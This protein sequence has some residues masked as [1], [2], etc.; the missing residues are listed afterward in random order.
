MA[1]RIAYQ[2]EIQP[3]SKTTKAVKRPAYLTWIR[4]LPCVVTKRSDV[5][6]AHLSFFRPDLGHFG[7][8]MSQKASDRWCLPLCVEQHLLQ[9][10]GNEQAYWRRHGIDPHLACLVLWG[11]FSELGADAT[12]EAGKIITK[13][14]GR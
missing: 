11:L 4:T 3:F 12:D 6:A 14:I 5:Q 8:G 9:H 13:G 1:T 7:R 10:A 2:G